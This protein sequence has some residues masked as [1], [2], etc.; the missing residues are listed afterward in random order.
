MVHARTQA[1]RASLVLLTVVCG[2][3]KSDPENDVLPAGTQAVVASETSV[4]LRVDPNRIGGM[5]EP[6]VR[7][8]VGD[9]PGF[10][11]ESKEDLEFYT[12]L[13]PPDEAKKTLAAGPRKFPPGDPMAKYR[14]VKVTVET[15]ECAGRSGSVTRHYLRPMK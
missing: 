9:D 1:R 11:L 3:G 2:C 4:V 12:R 14:K 8:T 15:G 10:H 13:L 7:V 6:G 5:L